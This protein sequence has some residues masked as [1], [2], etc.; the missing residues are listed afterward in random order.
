MLIIYGGLA[1]GGIETFF[2]RLAEES[3]NQNRKIKFLLLTSPENCNKELLSNLKEVAEVYF[4]SDIFIKIP[5]LGNRFFLINLFRKENILKLMEDI[6]LVHVSTAAHAILANK[7]FRYLKINIPITVGVYHYQEFCWG[8]NIPFFE[9]VHRHYIFKYIP[10]TNIMCFAESTKY[11]MENK[12]G[13]ELDGAKTFR[14]GVINNEYRDYSGK[15]YFNKN[16]VRICAVG[17]LVQFKTYNIWMV[18]VVSKLKEKGLNVVFDI[19][20]D[21]PLKEDILEKIKDNSINLKGSIDYSLFNSTV[22]EYDLFIGSGTAIIQA[23]ALGV[24]SIIGIESILKPL[25]YGYFSDFYYDEYH[26]P[27]LGLE[28]HDVDSLI[29][30]FFYMD[31]L[32]KKN[33]SDAHIKAASF[34]NMSECLENFYMPVNGYQKTKE[35]FYFNVCCYYFSRIFFFFLCKLK[36]KDIYFKGE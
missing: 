6:D 28:K 13:F 17:R 35:I 10:S 24:P 1:L 16:V 12:L 18:D 33:L 21:G 5:L 2:V 7:I 3:K 36:N 23:S 31:R 22:R 4:F 26:N 27:D 14:L 30:N 25:T 32:E 19:Y 9:K 20:G 15:N 34:F 11:Y 29:E 8:I